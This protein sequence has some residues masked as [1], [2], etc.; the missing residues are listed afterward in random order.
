M[1]G[2]F[3]STIL[4]STGN[5]F[6]DIYVETML[7]NTISIKKNKSTKILEKYFKTSQE[8]REWCEFLTINNVDFSKKELMSHGSN[9]N[10]FY[11]KVVTDNVDNILLINKKF[12]L[13]IKKDN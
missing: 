7:N 4:E 13:G 1:G 8:F 10:T 11:V 2:G 12:K 3:E 5:D 6:I 9:K